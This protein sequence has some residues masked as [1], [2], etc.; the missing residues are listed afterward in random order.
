MAT[1]SDIVQKI[2]TE[3][4]Q[5]SG[6]DVQTYAEPRVAQMLQREFNKA[7]DSRF[8]YEHSLTTTW[9]LGSGT[10]LVTTDLT[11]II[12]RFKDIQHVWLENSRNPLPVAPRDANPSQIT[13][14]CVA[15]YSLA[16]AGKFQILPTTASGNVTVRYRTQPADYTDSD[17]VAFDEDYLLFRCVTNF[18]VV[19]GTNL[20]AAE[21]YAKEAKEC[22]N[23][24]IREDMELEKSIYST[25]IS[26]V[27]NWNTR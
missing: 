6:P 26:N 19:E 1:F 2:M 13:Q 4:G 18:L 8:W 10:G 9:V 12:K 7:F 17:E 23:G 22:W 21:Y 24:L 14:T 20:K 25:T 15:P 11:N 3:L 27:D 16:T 5:A